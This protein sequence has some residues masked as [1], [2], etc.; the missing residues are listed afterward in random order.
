MSD[1]ALAWPFALDATGSVVTTFDEGRVWADRA[2]AVIGT[3]IGER[4]MRPTFGSAVADSLFGDTEADLIDIQGQV[5]NAFN[6]WLPDLSLQSTSVNGPDAKGIMRVEIDY[7]TPN[8][9]PGTSTVVVGS[10]ST[11][12]TFTEVTR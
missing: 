7:S 4:A 8:A 11:N 12:G 10:V 3:R 2:A 1:F 6:T 5:A 9:L